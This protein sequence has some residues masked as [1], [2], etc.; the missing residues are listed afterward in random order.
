MSTHLLTIKSFLDQIKS[1]SFWNRLFG[2]G[3]VNRDLVDA[4]AS[5][6]SLQTELGNTQHELAQTQ[7]HLSVMQE[8]RRRARL[9]GPGGRRSG[10]NG[11]PVGVGHAV[12][13]L[14]DEDG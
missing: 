14:G 1:L 10:V 7:M 3:A 8:T 2:W 4:A 6:A 5:L 12:G 11:S 13:G 9:W